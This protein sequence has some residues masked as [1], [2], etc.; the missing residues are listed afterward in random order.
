MRNFNQA[1]DAFQQG[2]EILENSATKYPALNNDL[3]ES[4]ADV[5]EEIREYRTAIAYYFFV[6]EN[7][8]QLSGEENQRVAIIY[9]K[10]GI[11]H[12]HM[13]DEKFV[14]YYHGESTSSIASKY[15]IKAYLLNQKLF[16]EENI[17]SAIN[18]FQ[19]G[20]NKYYQK[21][22][23][24]DSLGSCYVDSAIAILNT[25]KRIIEQKDPANV[26]RGNCYNVLGVCHLQHLDSGLYYFNKAY[27]THLENR[28]PHHPMTIH[29][30][31]N[32]AGEYGSDSQ[33]DLE[34]ALGFYQNA[35]EHSV[36]GFSPENIYDNPIGLDVIDY[37]FY[38]KALAGKSKLKMKQFECEQNKDDLLY[39]LETSMLAINTAKLLLEDEHLT[40][41]FGNRARRY[42]KCR[43]LPLR[44]TYSRIRFSRK[45]DTGTKRFP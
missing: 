39:A 9:E 8:I 31:L 32:L 29:A 23:N 13:F 5:Y 42:L 45:R 25:A 43:S 2:L 7:Q 21:F 30:A 20:L 37:N 27:Q 17:Y 34:T 44:F 3:Y 12:E 4:I 6:L 10:L 35:I 16:G 22:Y 14:R 33:E 36:P 40:V 28:G 41:E 11:C 18:L 26:K 24:D 15:F 38:M 19:L 1:I